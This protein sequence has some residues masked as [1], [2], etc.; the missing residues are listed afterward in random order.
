MFFLSEIIVCNYPYR[1]KS[2]PKFIILEFMSTFHYF[3]ITLNN[4]LASGLMLW[5]GKLFH[6]ERESAASNG[7]RQRQIRIDEGF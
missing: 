4:D 2:F 7:P 1:E 6:L 5:G 3:F